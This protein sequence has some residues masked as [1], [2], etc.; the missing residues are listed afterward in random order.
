MNRIFIRNNITIVSIVLFLMAYGGILF[1]QPG[2]LYNHDGS[3]RQFG[4]NSNRKTILPSWL[5]AIL[6]AI[7]SYLFVL[8]Y[9]AAPKLLY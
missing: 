5:I 9:L 3:L 8:Y 1:I 7:L 4:L 6:I 2:F